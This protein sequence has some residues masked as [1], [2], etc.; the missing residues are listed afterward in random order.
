MKS[1]ILLNLS[2]FLILFGVDLLPVHAQK[3]TTN[4]TNS[5]KDNNRSYI[6]LRYDP[7]PLLDAYKPNYL[8]Y[9]KGIQYFGGWVVG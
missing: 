3:N 4:R 7:P 6:G 9:P 5:N 8:D 1:K 2:V